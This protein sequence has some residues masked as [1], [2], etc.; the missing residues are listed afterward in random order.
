MKF[1]T[2]IKKRLHEDFISLDLLRKGL[3]LYFCVKQ[4]MTASIRVPLSPKAKK[5]S[6]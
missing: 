6:N 4:I 5:I 3:L 1:P 2:Y